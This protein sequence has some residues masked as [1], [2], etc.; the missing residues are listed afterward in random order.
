M[1]RRK[2][3]IPGIRLE[4]VLPEDLH[5]ELTIFLWSELEGR[6]PQGKYQEFFCARIREFFAERRLDLA[7][8][9]GM[10][11]EEYIV[12]GSSDTIE[13]LQKTLNEDMEMQ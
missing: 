8:W 3:L 11:E 1:S 13:L 2:N 4:T 10:P 12:R 5:A 7:A 9:T 6:V